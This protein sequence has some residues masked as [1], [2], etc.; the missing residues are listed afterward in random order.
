[1]SCVFTWVLLRSTLLQLILLNIIINESLDILIIDVLHFCTLLLRKYIHNIHMYKYCNYNLPRF[2]LHR[3]FLSLYKCPIYIFFL[4]LFST[5]NYFAFLC[6]TLFCLI[7]LLR[8]HLDIVSIP[9]YCNNKFP[10]I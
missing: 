1:M 8:S 7:R 2:F 6:I 9:K 5:R 10:C 4:L 3:F